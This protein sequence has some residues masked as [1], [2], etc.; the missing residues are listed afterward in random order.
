MP[1]DAGALQSHPPV[2]CEEHVAVDNDD[3]ERPVEA[4]N[5]HTGRVP[6]E[7]DEHQDVV[8]EHRHVDVEQLGVGEGAVG[9]VHQSVLHHNFVLDLHPTVWLRSVKSVFGLD[10]GRR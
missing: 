4:D 2:Y 8:D 3:H 5:L 9:E 7:D 10:R 1:G 6:A